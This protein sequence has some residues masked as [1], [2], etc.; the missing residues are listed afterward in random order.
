MSSNYYTFIEKILKKRVNFISNI[1]S[2]TLVQFE[3]I[4]KIPNTDAKL[5]K[6]T[7]ELWHQSCRKNSELYDSSTVCSTVV[8]YF[9][10][11]DDMWQISLTGKTKHVNTWVFGTH[12]CRSSRRINLCGTL[13][14][15]SQEGKL[16]CS[17]NEPVFI[18]GA[19]HCCLEFHRADSFFRNSETLSRWN[20][21]LAQKAIFLFKRTHHW[22]ITSAYIFQISA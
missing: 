7:L 22:F 3:N 4:H 15:E 13:A 10:N 5:Y 21:V 18:Y 2:G 11:T 8:K 6:F 14:V 9:K 19:E 16:Q 20:I 12:G 1:P 17:V